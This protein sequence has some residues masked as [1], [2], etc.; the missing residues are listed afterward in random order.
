MET[1]LMTQAMADQYCSIKMDTEE[2]RILAAAAVIAPDYQLGDLIGETIKIRDI[3]CERV[4]FTNEES[5]EITPGIRTVLIDME[6]KS[7]STASTGVYNS[8]KQLIAIFGE[9][10]WPDGVAVQVIAKNLNKKRLYILKP[11]ALIKD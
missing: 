6:G 3:Y 5:G 11:V 7:I 8:L 1:T 9:P 4:E 10:T 2:G